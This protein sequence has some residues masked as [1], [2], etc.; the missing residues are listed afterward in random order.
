VGINRPKM[1]LALESICLWRE[2]KRRENKPSTAKCRGIKETQHTPL[3]VETGKKKKLQGSE[4][5]G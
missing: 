3:T 5:V 1:S 2:G 4:E